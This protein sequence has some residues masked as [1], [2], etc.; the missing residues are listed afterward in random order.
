MR[1]L[2]RL[3]GWLILG[4][5]LAIL[6]ID[7]W[8]WLGGAR[9]LTAAGELWYRLHPDSLGLSQAVTQRYLFPWLWDPIA[10]WVL[11]Q[12]AAA[13]LGVIGVLII[14]LARR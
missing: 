4:A 2:F 9:K 11:L 7:A 14:F 1:T 3:L 8:S 13:V 6:V 5:A 12:P 10:V